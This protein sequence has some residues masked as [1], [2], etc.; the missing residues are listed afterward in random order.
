MD[1][2]TLLI[3]KVKLD[4]DQGEYCSGFK[5]RICASSGLRM[6]FKTIFMRHDI[7]IAS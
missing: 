6:K 3:K 7:D 1:L 4:S 2:K 5:T